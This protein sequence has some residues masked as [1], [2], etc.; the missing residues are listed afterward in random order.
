MPRVATGA[1]APD[2]ELLDVEIARLHG[3]DV[4]ALRARWRT[5]FRHEAPLHVPR[6]LLFRI[7]AYRLQVNQF[8]DLDAALRGVLDHFSEASTITELAAE[9]DRIRPG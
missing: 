7:L 4:Q 2:R 6:H 3:L 8:G 1:A 9:L 5:I